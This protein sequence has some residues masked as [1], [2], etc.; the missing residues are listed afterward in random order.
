MG[1]GGQGI[2][3]A[4]K[5][6]RCL[7]HHQDYLVQ[8]EAIES[9]LT[10]FGRPEEFEDGARILRQSWP[11]PRGYCNSESIDAYTRLAPRLP[12]D[13]VDEGAKALRILWPRWREMGCGSLMR[14]YVA[15]ISFLG[16]AEMIEGAK[17]LR[18]LC[19]NDFWCYQAN[20]WVYRALLPHLPPPAIWEEAKELIRDGWKDFPW[21]HEDSETPLSSRLSR[22]PSADAPKEARELWPLFDDPDPAVWRR[23]TEAYDLLIPKLTPLDIEETARYLRSRFQPGSTRIRE[24]QIHFYLKLALQVTPGE[25]AEG[26]KALRG[27]WDHYNPYIR[28]S[29]VDSYTTLFPRLDSEGKRRPGSFEDCGE[30]PTSL[31]DILLFEFITTFR[32]TCCSQ[33]DNFLNLRIIAMPLKKITT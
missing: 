25:A 13:E 30:T 29:A 3:Q 5:A 24:W 2:E 19:R 9:Y 17:D 32:P 18:A 1:D 16:A 8:A 12:A 22:L 33:N 15:L 14:G 20:G 11:D 4:A 28:E 26:A 23:V 31:F 27:L 7:W 6:L 10:L 21:A